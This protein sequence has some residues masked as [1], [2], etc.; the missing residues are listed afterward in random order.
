MSYLR[1]SPPARGRLLQHEYRTDRATFAPRRRKGRARP[2][3]G[4]PTDAGLGLRAA[5]AAPWGNGVAGTIAACPAT[6]RAR[7]RGHR[8]A[9]GPGRPAQP[10]ASRRGRVARRAARAAGRCRQPRGDRVAQP[11]GGGG[12]GGCAEGRGAVQVLEQGRGPPDPARAA[13]AAPLRPRPSTASSARAPTRAWSRRSAATS[14]ARSTRADG[15][16]APD[17]GRAAE[18]RQGPRRP[19][20]RAVQGRPARPDLRLRLHGGARRGRLGAVRAGHRGCADGARLHGGRRPRRGAVQGRE[21]GTNGFGRFF[22]KESAL[23][24]LAAG[25]AAAQHPGDRPLHHEPVAARRARRPAR[26]SRRAWRRATRRTTPAT[27]ATGRAPTST[28][29]SASSR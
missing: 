16:A 22:V 27:G 3:N 1:R 14:G 5:V 17:G 20:R 29:T 26:R 9:D 25:R 19:L 28:A 10:A 7:A 18:G 13:A 4:R 12:R 21:R 6:S 8:R 23:H 24:L 11:P 15:A 2:S